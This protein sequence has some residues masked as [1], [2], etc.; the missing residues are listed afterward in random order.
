M[1]ESNFF[2]QHSFSDQVVFHILNLG[3][4]I[5]TYVI[6]VY[7]G[8]TLLHYI[9]KCYEYAKYFKLFV[10]FQLC[11]I[12]YICIHTWSKDEAS[13]ELF[14]NFW[15]IFSNSWIILSVFY[16]LFFS[17]FQIIK[18]VIKSVFK[19]QDIFEE[20]SDYEVSRYTI[21]FLMPIYWLVLDADKSIGF[22][23]NRTGVKINLCLS[24][25]F[26]G[27][28]YGKDRTQTQVQQ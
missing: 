19:T 26:F 27:K 2:D 21:Y 6:L 11:Q 13:H 8:I 16:V 22:V 14:W 12:G 28:K 20:N 3:Q 9:Y 7:L 1:E 4:W 15:K 17:I 10:W 18:H 25:Y 5:N 23:E 24:K